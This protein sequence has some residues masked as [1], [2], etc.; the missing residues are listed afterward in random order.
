MN[1]NTFAF[2]GFALVAFVVDVAAAAIPS[3][4]YVDTIVANVKKLETPNMAVVTSE[5][6]EMTTGQIQS[7]MIADGSVTTDKIADLNVTEGKIADGAVTTNKILNG[8]VTT[9]KI[10][11]LNVTGTKIADGAVTVA[12]TTGLFGKVPSGGQG[13]TDASADIWVE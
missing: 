13:A 5:T 7:A 9:D 11:D 2:I 3:K 6:G 8:N 12:K 10:A 1:K 4:A